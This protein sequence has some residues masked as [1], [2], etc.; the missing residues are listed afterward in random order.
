MTAPVPAPAKPQAGKEYPAPAPLCPTTEEE[1]RQW[2]VQQEASPEF[3]K[4]YAPRAGVESANAE[5]KGPHGMGRLR[6][7]GESRVK[8]SVYFKVLACNVKRALRAWLMREREVE[9]AALA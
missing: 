5:I 3:K 6:V 9:K 4:K 1:A 7:R 2:Q 8:L